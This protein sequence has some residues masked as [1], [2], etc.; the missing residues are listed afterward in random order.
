MPQK[1]DLRGVGK[2]ARCLCLFSISS[3][4]A[5]DYRVVAARLLWESRVSLPT[6]GIL[7]C[8]LRCVYCGLAQARYFAREHRPHLACGCLQEQC[9]VFGETGG[10]AFNHFIVERNCD[11]LAARIR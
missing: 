1:N 10:D 6:P 9:A 5:A 4:S 3:I 7:A 2:R 11:G 8:G